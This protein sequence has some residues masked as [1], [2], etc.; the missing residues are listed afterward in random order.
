MQRSDER[1]V[2]WL[3]AI[4]VLAFWLVTIGP[5]MAQE[6]LP[7]ERGEPPA[8]DVPVEQIDS[9][10]VTLEDDDERR[11]LIEQL[12]LLSD[13]GRAAESTEKYWDAL[14]ARALSYL[15]ERSAA[16]GQQVAE[17]GA[18]LSDVPALVD[19]IKDEWSSAEA[20]VRWL[21][22]VSKL[23]IVIGASLAGLWLFAVPLRRRR[24]A[25]ELR[26]TA[27]A[28]GRLLLNLAVMAM[29][30]F[31]LVVFVV[32][33]NAAIA[34]VEPR[35]ETRIIVLAFVNA[36]LIRGAIQAVVRAIVS[37]APGSQRILPVQDETAAYLYVWSRRLATT[38]VFG[39]V[40]AATG[41]LLGMSD[42]VFRLS[43]DLV[44][45]LIAG[46]LMVLIAQNRHAVAEAIR[47]GESGR[48]S[49]ALR[50]RLADAWHVLAIVYIV[51]AYVI[52]LLDIAGGAAFILRATVLSVI[53]VA[54]LVALVSAIHR[55]IAGGLS[56]SPELKSEYPRLE[57]RAN[58]YLPILE[59]VIRAILLILGVLVL[60]EIW[61]LGG[62]AFLTS[63]IGRGLGGGALSIGVTLLV[64]VLV[65]ELVS[66][67]VEHRLAGVDEDGDPIILSGRVKTLLP[68]MRKVVF[69]VL[70]TLVTLIVL[71]EL[72]VNI[73]P[74]LAGAG[75]AGLAVGF[76]AQT[77]VKD[78]ITGLFILIE[79][80]ITVGDVVNVGGHAGLVE[81]ISL[82]TLTLRDLSGVVHTVPYS[83]VDTVMN[84]T[85]DFSFYVME[86]GVSYREDVDQ[87]T[88]VVKQIGAELLEDPKYAI[89]ILEPVEI[90][91]LDQ[92]ADSAVII[93]ARIKTKPIK[94]WF[95]GRE[96]NRRMKK[97]FDEL[98]IEIPFPH[99]TLYFGQDKAGNAPPGHIRL[100]SPEAADALI[101]DQARLK[102]AE[103]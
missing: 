102:S 10:I 14:G 53:A 100:D 103:A 75:I 70:A 68:L 74:L 23:S 12:R 50:R 99:M 31:P 44:G 97:R 8:V 30:L 91:G 4:V 73:A 2:S 79:D 82:R 47:A 25:L 35:P 17:L 83:Q 56:I 69:V 89:Q 71:S 58:R 45:L 52:W 9:L 81:A 86:I 55:L 40:V 92:F 15:S 93:K 18:A 36:I 20:R 39:Y 43:I 24:R 42:A 34:L 101:A 27:T 28:T 41:L 54:G 11:Q 7:R 29:S 85:K 48:S 84:L 16:L 94:Q 26:R 62:F 46:L 19:W 32:V 76:G 90:L 80:T 6:A 65:W 60:L 98:G 87:V 66:H 57:E 33:A 13:A 38:A 22:V 1:S 64:A 3:F 59:R 67:L 96:F 95:V 37:P 78:I 63:D 61:N 88:E 51:I 49:G 5:A 21:D 77:L 72:G